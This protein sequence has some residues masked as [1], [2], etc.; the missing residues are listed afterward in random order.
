[1]L[2]TFVIHTFF[3]SYFHGRPS[4]ENTKYLLLKK[5]MWCIYER[6]YTWYNN[7]VSIIILYIMYN[8]WLQTNSETNT[9]YY[10]M[11]DRIIIIKAKYIYKNIM[12][13][14]VKL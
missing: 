1:M 10:Y 6:K 4:K 13:T 8:L 14:S 11:Y 3:T 5:I 12:N 2:T 7:V 9:Y